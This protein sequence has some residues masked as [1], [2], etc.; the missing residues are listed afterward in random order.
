MKL[1]LWHGLIYGERNTIYALAE[2]L[3]SAKI[4]ALASAPLA[5]EK[6]VRYILENVGPHIFEES[7]S[8]IFKSGGQL[9]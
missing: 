3:K 5:A 2:D 7:T 9:T 6:D 4:I 1:F 8:F